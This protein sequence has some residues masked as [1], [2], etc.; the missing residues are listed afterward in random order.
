MNSNQ[1]WRN[2]QNIYEPGNISNQIQKLP[3]GVY[4]Y[5]TTPFGWYLQKIS[6]LFEFPYKLYGINQDLLIRSQKAWENTT[7]NLGIIL[8]GLRGAGKTVSGQT[9]CNKLISNEE[10]PVILISY[11]IDVA[12]IIEKLNQSVVFFFDEFEKTHKEETA[13]QQ[14]LTIVDGTSKSLNKHLFLFTTNENNINPNFLDRTSR[15]RYIYNFSNLEVS[16]INEIIDDL[17]DP[18]LKELSL[19]IITYLRTREVQS[20]DTVKSTIQEANLFR[21]APQEFEKF[22]N[23]SKKSAPAFRITL[24]DS[25]NEEKLVLTEY[26]THLPLGLVSALLSGNA[27]AIFKEKASRNEKPEFYIHTYNNPFTLMPVG[28][29]NKE[30]ILHCEVLIKPKFVLREYSDILDDV[31][32]KPLDVKLDNFKFPFKTNSELLRM[33]HAEKQEYIESI[34]DDISDYEYDNKCIY[35]SLKPSI[36]RIKFEIIEKGN[37]TTNYNIAL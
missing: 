11:P 6:K 22:F 21:E 16:T 2:S 13:Q 19:S 15:V 34:S 25:S 14:L 20:I 24:I 9:L 36:F 8:T 12:G 31:G 1:I 7:A 18:E 37:Y 3:G 4:K 5:V 35:G 10:I 32:M 28:A 27:D 29:E 26:C 33:R 17:L 23:L 30:N